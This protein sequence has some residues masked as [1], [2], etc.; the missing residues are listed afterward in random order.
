M[1]K[2]TAPGY[3]PGVSVPPRS[4]LAQHVVFG[5]R[6]DVLEPFQVLVLGDS[7]SPDA[8]DDSGAEFSLHRV[9]E[10]PRL[11]QVHGAAIAI[12]YVAVFLRARESIRRIS[13][14]R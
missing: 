13:N 1:Q 6:R 3:D 14:Y 12:L 8:V 7:F 4:Q 11:L 5:L 2:S 10:P 9:Q